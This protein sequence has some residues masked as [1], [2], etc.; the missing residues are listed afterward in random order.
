V[1]P[2]LGFPQNRFLAFFFLPFRSLLLCGEE[3]GARFIADPKQFVD[4]LLMM[5][6]NQRVSYAFLNSFQFFLK[7]NW[8]L[9]VVLKSY[10]VLSFNFFYLYLYLI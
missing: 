6:K 9:A 1:N 8:F 3:R 4:V 7:K 2:A 10:S 5:S